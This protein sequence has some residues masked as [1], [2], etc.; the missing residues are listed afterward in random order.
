[1]RFKTLVNYCWGKTP[2]RTESKF[3]KNGIHPWIFIADMVAV[4]VIENTK[5]K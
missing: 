1:V 4:G 5:A 3:W 2:P